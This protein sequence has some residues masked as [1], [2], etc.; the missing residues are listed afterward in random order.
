MNQNNADHHELNRAVVALDLTN[1]DEELLHYTKFLAEQIGLE[2]MEFI[3]ALPEFDIF[4]SSYFRSFNELGVPTDL[5]ETVWQT[6]KT[7]VEK[8]LGGSMGRPYQVKAI[9]GKPLEVIL[10]RAEVSQADLL[11]V[12]DKDRQHTQGV[13][14]KN[15]IRKA[16]GNVL[17]V[18]EKP[19]ESLEHIL[20]AIDFSENSARALQTAVAIGAKTNAPAAITCL[21]V[22]DMPLMAPYMINRTAEEFKGMTEAN[23]EEA[24][25]QFVKDHAAGYPGVINRLLREKMVP[26]V[27]DYILEIAQETGAGLIVIGAKGHSYLERLMIGSVTERLVAVNQR[28]PVLVVK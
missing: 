24:F 21:N 3:H 23:I 25:N 12:G 5:N 17:L 26:R 4:R 14:A 22:Y 20:V 7:K 11:V 28:I 15:I 19:V 10:N 2:K 13:L 27:S 16:A 6:A 1:M 18:P 9:V 8:V